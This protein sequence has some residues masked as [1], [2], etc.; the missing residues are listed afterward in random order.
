MIKDENAATTAQLR[1]GRTNLLNKDPTRFATS[2]GL[3]HS[4]HLYYVPLKNE[5]LDQ[6]DLQHDQK[7]RQEKNFASSCN[8]YRQMSPQLLN[9]SKANLL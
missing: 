6:H 8:N 5:S 2:A 3:R 4:S 9:K 7:D 1:E